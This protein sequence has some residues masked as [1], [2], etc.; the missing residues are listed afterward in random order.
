ME[1]V[2]RCVFG[3]YKKT[4]V[5]GLFCFFCFLFFYFFC[6]LSKKFGTVVFNFD[7]VKALL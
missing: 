3:R 6:L 7:S 4:N 5:G 1:N 2:F